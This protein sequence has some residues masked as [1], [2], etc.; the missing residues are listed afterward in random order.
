MIDKELDDIINDYK[1]YCLRKIDCVK[2]RA[3]C[4][5]GI[6]LRKVLINDIIKRLKERL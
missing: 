6:D 5:D 4:I 3:I 1:N 2:T